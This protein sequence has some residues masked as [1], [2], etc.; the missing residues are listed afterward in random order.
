M[1]D[2]DPQEVQRMT[3]S[4]PAQLP[5]PF[6]EWED[7]TG[8]RKIMQ[9]LSINSVRETVV[10]RHENGQIFPEIPIGSL[11]RRDRDYLLGGNASQ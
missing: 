7:L 10:F 4:E 5:T 11:V 8:R 1:S 6:R 2:F 3:I 9:A